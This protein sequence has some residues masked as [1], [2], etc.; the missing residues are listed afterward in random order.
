MDISD[1]HPLLLLVLATE[2]SLYF[3]RHMSFA[4]GKH[5][6]PLIGV[7]EVDPVPVTVTV[8]DQ[9]ME[10]L[11]STWSATD[12]VLASA[13]LHHMR[14]K[15]SAQPGL[16]RVTRDIKDTVHMYKVV[17]S[18]NLEAYALTVQFKQGSMGYIPNGVI[19]I[20]RG[21]SE[22]SHRLDKH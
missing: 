12:P 15:P 11:W 18:V 3:D 10:E 20:T 19:S 5:M 6:A 1:P 14:T 9:R 8:G 2:G 4:G 17:R 7:V 13:G 16:N 21:L 22:G